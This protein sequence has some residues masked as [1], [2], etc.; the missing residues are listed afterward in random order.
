MQECLRDK[1]LNVLDRLS[2]SPDFTWTRTN[3]SRDL[4]LAGQR[5]SPINLTEVERICREEWEKF[6]KYRCAKLEAS[7]PRRLEVV[8][9]ANDASTQY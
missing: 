7:Y 4:K 9:A 8:I 5:Y 6:T 3:I 1:S 2:Q